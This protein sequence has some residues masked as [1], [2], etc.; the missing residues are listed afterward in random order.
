MCIHLHKHYKKDMQ[1]L[2]GKILHHREVSS[3]QTYLWSQCLPNQSINAL[4]GK[5]TKIIQ[6][7]ILGDKQGVRMA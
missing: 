3:Q 5:V 7:S 6:T 2:D 4:G 1:D